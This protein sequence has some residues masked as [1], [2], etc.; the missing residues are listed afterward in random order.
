MTHRLRTLTAIAATTALAFVSNASGTAPDA[1]AAATADP[2]PEL[3][4]GDLATT[5]GTTEPPA[6]NILVRRP[7][8][9]H[10]DIFVTPQGMNNATRGPQIMDDRGRPIWFRELPENYFAT[11]LRVQEYQGKKVLTWWEGQATN[12]GKGTGI[13]YIADENYR[14]I[15]TVQTPDVRQVMDL[16]EF[17]LTPQ[18]TALIVSYQQKPYD[19]SQAG[20]AKD[21]R[22]VDSVVQE[23]DIATGEKLLNW[24]ALEHVPVT[25]SDLRTPPDGTAPYDFLHVNSVGL[26][27][28]GNLLISGNAAS[29]VYKVDRKTGGIIW[30]LGGRHSDFRLGIGARF[31]WQHD[32]RAAG[33]HTY[34][35]YDNATPNG[36]QGYESRVAWIR[37]DPKTRTA[38]LVRQLTHPDKMSTM[39]E[40]GSQSL[41]NGN[42]FVCWAASVPGRISEFS[43]DG[44]LIFDATFTNSRDTASYRAYRLDWDGTSLAKPKLLTEDAAEGTVR[45]NWNGASD[46]S[47]WRLLAG[48]ATGALKPVATA[49]WDGFDTPITVPARARDADRLQVQALDARGHVVGTSAVTP[50]GADQDG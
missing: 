32:V 37:I 47:R 11:D 29:T 14:I 40:G 9:A 2:V 23:I 33:H 31:Q 16:H 46:V 35:I 7:G 34:R 36:L 26:D 48:G 19:L 15:A 17:T 43:R 42:T 24:S 20:G 30:R 18:G 21:G 49:D 44:R 5:P 39:R 38:E 27:T 41:P 50:A 12:T 22:V 4:P 10:G 8:R 25:D 1:R 45:A 28:D 3:R 6:A 13:G